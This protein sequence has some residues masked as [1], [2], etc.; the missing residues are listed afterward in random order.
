MTEKEFLFLLFGLI[1]STLVV[2]ILTCV[3]IFYW[4]K[5]N[6][7]KLTS[8]EFNDKLSQNKKMVEAEKIL[9]DNNDKCNK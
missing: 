1:I 4:K 9:R 7:K 5:R 3:F 8:K 2:V 6:N